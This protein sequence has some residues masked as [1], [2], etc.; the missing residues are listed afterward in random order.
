V[1]FGFFKQIFIRD[2]HGHG[3]PSTPF[4]ERRNLLTLKLFNNLLLDIIWRISQ[5]SPLLLP[6]PLHFKHFP[7]HICTF[8]PSSRSGVA[9]PHYSLSLL[10]FHP[11]PVFE[12]S[13][14]FFSP[15]PILLYCFSPGFKFGNDFLLIKSLLEVVFLLSPLSRVLLFL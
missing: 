3:L 1:V 12:T 7:S 15:G 13:H 14:S 10:L 6:F 11:S 4:G 2:Y 9:P 5:T 8:P